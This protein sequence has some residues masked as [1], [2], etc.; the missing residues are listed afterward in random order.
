M[1]KKFNFRQNELV[2]LTCSSPM[3]TPSARLMVTLNGNSITS[4]NNFYQKTYHTQYDNGQT[5]TSVNVQFPSQWLHNR[6]NDFHC[7]SSIIHRYNRT[8]SVKFDARNDADN[9]TAYYLEEHVSLQESNFIRPQF[10]R[11]LERPF[12]LF[13]NTS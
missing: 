4:N 7:T 9:R 8:A 11:K 6:K 12:I 5:T 1:G 13:Q 3:S 2:N 10:N